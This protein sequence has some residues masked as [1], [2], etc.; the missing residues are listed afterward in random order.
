MA[1]LCR[2]LGEMPSAYYL[3]EWRTHMQENEL[4]TGETVCRA[5]LVI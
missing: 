5:Q 1:T 4:V 3:L 2:A